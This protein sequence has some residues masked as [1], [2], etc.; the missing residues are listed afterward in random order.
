MTS[1]ALQRGFMNAIIVGIGVFSVI[2]ILTFGIAAVSGRT[3]RD[4]GAIAFTIFWVVI[5]VA[6]VSNFLIDR[7][8][9]GAL[10]LDCGP[11][12]TR[13][14]FLLNAVIFAF[15]GLSGGFASHSFD[16][17][18]IA[19]A[20]FGITFS[21]YWVVMSVGRLQIVENGIWQYWGLLKWH[22]LE[23][24]E[25]QD[26]TNPTLMLQTTTKIPLFGR[27]ALPVPA[28]HAEAVSKL[29]EHYAA[30]KHT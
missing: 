11:H 14:L 20:M 3:V 26:G 4:S 1:I 2:A 22:K 10:L 25:W 29:L 9:R 27:G 18:G 12:P 30:H 23:S 28:E 6:F 5:F 7:S 15:V 16:T 21:I 8:N 24:Y 13:V 19:G 17:F